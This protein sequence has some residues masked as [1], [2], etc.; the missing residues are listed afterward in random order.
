MTL[1]EI[2]FTISIFFFFYYT[3]IYLELFARKEY[4]IDR[5]QAH[6]KDF[7]FLEFIWPSEVRRPKIS[8]PR[9]I[10]I[11]LCVFVFFF[12]FLLFVG[13]NMWISILFFSAAPITSFSIVAL[14]VFITSL[15]VFVYRKIIT[16]LASKRLKKYNPFV[17]GV[18]G[19][20]GKSTT[21]TYI[22]HV[23]SRKF[24]VL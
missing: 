8:H 14:A 16:N 7:G 19:S 24:K 1:K 5:L 20:Y 23:L 3:I 15:P 4:R 2:L 12:L 17:I 21:K 18:T 9:N 6:I 10:L 22:A 13:F 11:S